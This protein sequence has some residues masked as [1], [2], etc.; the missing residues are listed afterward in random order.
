MSTHCARSAESTPT[1]PGTSAQGVQWSFL[2]TA[3]HSLLTKD[4]GGWTSG[5]TPSIKK[6]PSLTWKEEWPKKAQKFQPSW[7]KPGTIP[8][9]DTEAPTESLKANIFRIHF[10][11]SC[12]LST[13]CLWPGS[14][15][16]RPYKTLPTD[17]RRGIFR[18]NSHTTAPQPQGTMS[19]THFEGATHSLDTSPKQVPGPWSAFP[20][21]CP[22]LQQDGPCRGCFARSVGPLGCQSCSGRAIKQLQSFWPSQHNNP[23]SLRGEECGD[24]D[25]ASRHPSVF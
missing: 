25:G 8:K 22:R 17:A 23:K 2:I 10:S 4:I 20:L 24:L 14:C 3:S 13:N 6:C 5:D 19:Q 21:L 15:L 16:P 18:G 11:I 9:H 12:H 1:S 7:D